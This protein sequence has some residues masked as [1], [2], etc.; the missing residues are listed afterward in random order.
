[1][2]SDADEFTNWASIDPKGGTAYPEPVDCTLPPCA[3][4]T[5]IVQ[6]TAGPM[7]TITKAAPTIVEAGGELT[8]TISVGNV[9]TANLLDGTAFSVLDLLWPGTTFVTQDPGTGVSAVTCDA[10]A[11][12]LLDCSVTLAGDLVAGTLPADGAN[13]TITVTAPVDP[14]DA[15]WTCLPITSPFRRMVFMTRRRQGRPAALPLPAPAAKSAG[16][17]ADAAPK[18]SHVTAADCAWFADAASTGPANCDTGCCELLQKCYATNYE[19]NSLTWARSLCEGQP[20][21]TVV[22]LGDL[23][24]V[25]CSAD[26]VY[27][28]SGVCSQCNNVALSC[29][30]AGCSSTQDPATATTCNDAKVS[31]TLSHATHAHPPHPTVI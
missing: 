2:P 28:V 20:V 31:H 11:A 27:I 13:F 7:L 22:S 1:M 8:Y 15:R 9:G 24:T 19:C 10:T 16:A 26:L 30:Q 14:E 17:A 21:G 18:T 29:V 12:P 4:Y 5:T 6:T 25:E 23:G 3:Q